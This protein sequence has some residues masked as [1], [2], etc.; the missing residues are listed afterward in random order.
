MGTPQ[1][2]VLTHEKNKGSLKSS[3]HFFHL[4]SVSVFFGEKQNQYGVYCSLDIWKIFNLFLEEQIL[5]T[6]LEIKLLIVLDIICS[7]FLKIQ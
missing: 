6:L 4:V 7:L 5:L 1:E 2:F 3:F